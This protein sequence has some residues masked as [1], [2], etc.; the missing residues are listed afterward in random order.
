MNGLS[1]PFDTAPSLGTGVPQ[2]LALKNW[3]R[4]PDMSVL[5]HQFRQN[6]EMIIGLF[7]VLDKISKDVS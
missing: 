3:D 5:S 2:D 6:V 7:V 1:Y 4:P